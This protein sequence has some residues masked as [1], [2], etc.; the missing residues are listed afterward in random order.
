MWTRM[1]VRMMKC[2][3]VGLA[4]P[5]WHCV[6]GKRLPHCRDER[7][8]HRRREITALVRMMM[9]TMMKSPKT[10]HPQSLEFA[11]HEIGMCQC[12]WELLLARDPS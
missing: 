2:G 3:D 6:R 9:M 1:K 10:N 5:V 12:L 7:H 11:D 8:R 4:R